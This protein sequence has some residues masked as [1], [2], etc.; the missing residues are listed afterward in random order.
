LVLRDA[1][2]YTENFGATPLVNSTAHNSKGYD[3]RNTSLQP[4]QVGSEN[5]EIYGRRAINN[6]SEL[7]VDSRSITVNASYVSA[8][9]P[10]FLLKG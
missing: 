8:A 5:H 1:V 9:V 3:T 4:S 2:R 10:S 7:L 6:N